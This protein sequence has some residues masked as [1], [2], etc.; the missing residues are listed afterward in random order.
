[1]KAAIKIKVWTELVISEG[2]AGESVPR[3]CLSFCWYAGNLGVH[4]L[5]EALPQLLHESSRGLLPF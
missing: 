2:Y 3:L 4:C 5:A 1:M